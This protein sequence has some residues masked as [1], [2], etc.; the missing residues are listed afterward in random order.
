MTIV[1]WGAGAF[2]LFL[3]GPRRLGLIVVEW[4]TIEGVG[5]SLFC[6]E[7]SGGGLLLFR[8]GQVG[9][10]LGWRGDVV[11]TGAYVGSTRRGVS[12]TIVC[13]RRTLTRVHTKGTDAQLLSNVHISSCKDVI[14]VD[15]MTTIAAPSTH[16]VTVGP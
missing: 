5:S 12:V 8:L 3:V 11:S 4:E 16:D 15:G 9:G 6:Y 7:W 1:Q 10:R 2:R 13:L 14:P